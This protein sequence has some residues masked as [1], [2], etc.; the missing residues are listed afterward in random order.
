MPQSP[1]PV[2]PQLTGL[3]IAYRNDSYIADSIAPYRTVGKR[4]FEWD[5]YTL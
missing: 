1:Y 4:Q 3:A 5:D 2:D